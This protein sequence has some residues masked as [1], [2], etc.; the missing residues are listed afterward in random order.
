[1]S[2][3]LTKIAYD[4]WLAPPVIDKKLY[5]KIA[6]NARKLIVEKYSYPSIAKKLDDI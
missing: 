5:E 3:N 6:N 4:F 1:M 2:Q